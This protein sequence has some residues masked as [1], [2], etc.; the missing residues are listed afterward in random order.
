MSPPGPPGGDRAIAPDLAKIDDRT[1]WSVVN[2]E[3]AT[4]AEGDRRVVRLGPRG[5]DTKG[6]N[7]GLA[8]VKGLE[9]D[10]GAIE[11]DLKG[12]GKEQRSF[13]G[14]AFGAAGGA[15]FEAVY[16]RPFN[17]ETDDPERRGH[18]VQYVAW[19]GH[20]WEAL[21]AQKP[22]AYESRVAPAPDPAGWFHA[23][24]EVAKKQ[25][26][27]FVNHAD[28][29]CLVVERLGR[30]AKGGVGLWVDSQEGSFANLRVWPATSGG[31]APLI[32]TRAPAST[33]RGEVAVFRDAAPPRSPR[34]G[35][36]LGA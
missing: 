13:L 6:S 27:V 36:P 4:G 16:F 7:V 30:P 8:L 26:R 25:V 2:G 3:S 29:P 35:Y 24:V 31:P 32:S 11:V 28:E 5:G 15:A 10:E 1:V 23:R 17:F 12:K 19:P 21:R 34:A 20:T 33:P 18:A 14:V 9:F 22:G